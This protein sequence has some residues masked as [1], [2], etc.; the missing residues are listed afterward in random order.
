M[1]GYLRRDFFRV[2]GYTSYFDAQI[3]DV[4]LKAQRA[5]GIGGAMA[6]IG[7]HHGRSFFILARARHAGEKALAVDVFEDD[8]LYRDPLGFGRGGRFKQNCARL[9]VVL[10]PSEIFAGLSTGLAPN[11]IRRRV[12]PVRF[13]SI[14][15]G[16]RYHDV[17]HD[18]WLAAGALGPRGIIVA[19]DFM[20]PQWPEVSLAVVE[21]LR[22][23]GNPLTPFLSSPSKLYLCARSD[24]LF[25]QKQARDF[26]AA[27]RAVMRPTTL[28]DDTYYF[29]RQNSRD[30]LRDL[31]KE[32]LVSRWFRSAPPAAALPAAQPAE[33]QPLPHKHAA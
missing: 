19:D 12:G 2:E 26:F 27:G 14:D 13:F 1:T 30:K 18:L 7:V 20:N 28:F 29:A 32:R 4:L 25:Y 5:A 15:G 17:R 24:K 16:H 3:F 21:W 31:I 8:A 10:D 22:D 9:G 11:E 33:A 23:A 6:E